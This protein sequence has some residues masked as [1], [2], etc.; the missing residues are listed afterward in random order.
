MRKLYETQQ[1]EQREGKYL[2]RLLWPY[3]GHGLTAYAKLAYSVL[4]GCGCTPKKS[5][6]LSLVQE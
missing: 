4:Q 2:I 3:V 5:G 6:Q 1:Q